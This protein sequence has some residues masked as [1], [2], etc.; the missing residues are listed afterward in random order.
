MEA[1]TALEDR[2]L[3]KKHLENGWAAIPPSHPSVSSRLMMSAL[4]TPSASAVKL[5]TMR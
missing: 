1:V 2:E 3:S 4:V 5:G